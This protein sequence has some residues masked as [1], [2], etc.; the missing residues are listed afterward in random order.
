MRTGEEAWRTGM[1]EGR[2]LS[3]VPT[4]DGSVAAHQPENANGAKAILFSVDPGTGELA[5]LL[6]IGPKAHDDDGLTQHVRAF[7]FGGDNHQAVWRDGLFIVFTTTHRA[8]SRGKVD[9]VAFAV[10]R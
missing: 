3:L 7:G 1:V 2:V 4:A 5:P 6:P 8:A 10:S 9:M